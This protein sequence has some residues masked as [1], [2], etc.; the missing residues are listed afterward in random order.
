MSEDTANWGDRSQTGE[1]GPGQADW[2]T[3]YAQYLMRSA[4]QS[5][6]TTELYQQIMDCVARGQLAPTVFRDALPT[7]AQT[8]GT[9]YVNRLAEINTRFLGEMVQLNSIYS[10]ELMEL[11][12]PGAS[13]APT[14]RR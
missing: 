5:A 6:K 8:R 1:A 10:Q 2:P 4:S 7:F 13:A 3:L 11:V 14:P 9:A 12:L